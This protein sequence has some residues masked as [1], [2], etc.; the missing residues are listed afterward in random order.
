MTILHRSFVCAVFLSFFAVAASAGTINYAGPDIGPGGMPG[1]LGDDV[2]YGGVSESNTEG[3]GGAT[4][5]LFGA[6]ASISGN[7]I[8]FNP[9]NFV[10][11]ST[12]GGADIT[13]GQL[14]FMV[15]ATAG[16][17]IDN[18]QFSE[19]GD[20]TLAGS[21]STDA[22]L[23]TVT[24][25]IF[26]DVV[27]I[28]GLPVAPLNIQASMTFSP[29]DGDYFLNADSGGGFVFATAWSGLA[30]IDINQ[31]LIDAGVSFINGAT[32]LNVTVDNTLTAVSIDGTS[33]FIKKK[34]FDGITVTSNIPEPTTALLALLAAAGC[35]V[36]SRRR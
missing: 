26:I 13:D 16:Q 17:V 29:S 12:D 23:T 6:P 9:T 36:A 5:G 18:L 15:V 7:A 4:A 30:L 31:E 22:T 25:E 32:K 2:W 24:A 3:P 35:G 19:A 33:A 28:D 10:A 1:W 27:Q 21:P 20:T 14:S 8:D 11:E 34:D